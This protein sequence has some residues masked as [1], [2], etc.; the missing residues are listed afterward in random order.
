MVW[1]EMRELK[2]SHS[3]IFKKKLLSSAVVWQRTPPCLRPGS[4]RVNRLCLWWELSVN[5][6][7]ARCRHLIWQMSLMLGSGCQWCS[8]QF[9]LPSE[10][11]SH[12]GSCTFNASCCV[13]CQNVCCHSSVKVNK[14]LTKEFC[15]L[16]KY[17]YFWA[18]LTRLESMTTMIGCM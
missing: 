18:I 3:L 9:Y 12:P 15:F 8:G 1:K 17:N 4:R 10:E 13:S 2:K 11:C 16:E 5:I 14:N 7:L 6:L